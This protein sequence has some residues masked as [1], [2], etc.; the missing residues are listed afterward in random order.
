[1][2]VD[3]R[4]VAALLTAA[5]PRSTRGSAGSTPGPSYSQMSLPAVQRGGSGIG[6]AAGVTPVIFLKVRLNAASD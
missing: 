2:S 5:Y 3:W 4:D 1:V 6:Q